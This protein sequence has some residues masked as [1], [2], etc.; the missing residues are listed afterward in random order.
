MKK[1]LTKIK[2][3]YSF[4]K[5]SIPFTDYFLENV[6]ETY[7]NHHKIIH[8]RNGLPVY[9]LS[10]PAMYSKPSANL[11]SKLLFRVIQ[12]KTTPNLMSFAINDICNANCAHCSFYEEVDDKTK[13]RLTTDEIINVISQAQEIG[14]TMINIVGGEPLL[15]K[16]IGKI[17]KSVNKDKSE[18]IM[19]TNGMLLSKK[20]P[21]LKEAG[22]NGLYVSIDASTAEMHDQKRGKKG[23]FNKALEGLKEAIKEGLTVGISCVVDENDFRQGELDN[24][25]ELAKSL[26]VHE[27]LVFDKLPVGRLKNQKEI[28]NQRLWIQEMI[29]SVKKY[30]QDLDYP[31]I[32]VYAYVTSFKSIGCSCGTSYF[33]V[34]PYGEINPCDFYHKYFGN[35]REEPL[36]KIIDKMSSTQGFGESSWKGCGFKIN[37]ENQK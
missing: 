37:F 16:D 24:I 27:V 5:N 23:L 26:G 21:E 4:L 14:V 10:T 22:L 30:N 31:G 36:Y 15:H 6:Y 7:L 11:F 19:F 34:T 33:Y 2:S 20:L 29:E 17:I 3:K 18:V 35:V 8:F 28:L 32:L 13:Q 25:I 9:S 1:N 12:N